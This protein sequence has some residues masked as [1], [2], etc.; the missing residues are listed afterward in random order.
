MALEISKKLVLEGKIDVKQ[1][2]NSPFDKGIFIG[3]ECIQVGSFAP[4]C[5]WS[6]LMGKNVKITIELTET[7]E[8]I[9]SIKEDTDE[10]EV[11]EKT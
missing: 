2:S 1:F 8:N 5:L 10:I 11:P 7:N 4:K 3:N 9:P 6:K